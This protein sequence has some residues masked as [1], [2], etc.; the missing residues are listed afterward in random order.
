[1][2]K[3]TTQLRYYLTANTDIDPNEVG[4]NNINTVYG[5]GREELFDFYYPFHKSTVLEK[6]SEQI[7]FENM[8]CMR[9]FYREIGFETI[10]AFK[11]HLQSLLWE[12]MN[13]YNQLFS[14]LDREIEFETSLFDNINISD[15]LN[16][17]AARTTD[18][19]TK[20]QDTKTRAESYQDENENNTLSEGTRATSGNTKDWD[21]YS[22]TPQGTLT[23]VNNENYLTTAEKKTTE[24]AGS[25]A[26]TDKE[27]ATGSASGNRS[28]AD[29]GERKETVSEHGTDSKTNLKTT[30][31]RSGKPL[32]EMFIEWRERFMNIYEMILNDCEVLFLGLW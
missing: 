29:T 30:K 24:T 12:K 17:T 28:S 7:K 9:F 15:V 31:G 25:E 32:Y 10:G 5:E 13:Y 23:N 26:S 2:S 3:Y 8:F 1:M 21:L 14:A 19:D 20:A 22:D 4:F 6:S 18:R 16:E 27:K 11:Q